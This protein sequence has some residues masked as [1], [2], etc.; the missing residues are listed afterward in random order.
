MEDDFFLLISFALVT[1]DN[2][3]VIVVYLVTA[4]WRFVVTQFGCS[5]LSQSGA[6]GIPCQAGAGREQQP[7][8]LIPGLK[9][10]LFEGNNRLLLL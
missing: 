10:C 1:S 5:G 4:R 8:Q 6:A 2:T 9:C 3:F 7:G